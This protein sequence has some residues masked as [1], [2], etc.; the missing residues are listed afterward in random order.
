MREPPALPGD[1]IVGALGASFGIRV[2]ELAFLPIGNDSASWSYR[3]EAAGEPTFFLKVRAGGGHM[4]GAAVPSYLHGLGVPHVLAP[5]PTGTGAPYILV[6]G[7]ALALYPMLDATVGGEVGLS[8]GQWRQLG[9][10]MRQVHTIPRTPRLSGMV[11]RD[12]FRPTRRELIG[13][14]EAL[15]TSTATPDDP[16]AAEL[17][18]FWRARRDVISELVERVDALGR[19][20]ARARLPQVLCHGDLHTWNVLVGAD[21]RLWIVDWDEAMLSPRE[22]D[23]MFVVGGIRHGLVRPRDTEC[24]FEGYGEATVDQRLLTYY[25]AAWAVQDIA[26]CGE[27]ALLMPNLQVETRQAAA[28]DLTD[29]FEPGRIV[30]IARASAATGQDLRSAPP[31]S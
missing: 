24:F 2:T 4:T 28:R 5:L 6:D 19:Q 18:G 7:F 11:G 1:T 26:A 27:E 13:E 14:L 12:A 31:G 15:L 20:L 30:D 9:A 21:R 10:T 23:L 8:P 16:V 3:V 29:L 17:A 25:R 22:R